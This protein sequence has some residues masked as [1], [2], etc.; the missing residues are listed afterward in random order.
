[1]R[2]IK[3]VVVGAGLALAGC[4]GEQ[5]PC[6]GSA[7]LSV[8]GTYTGTLTQTKAA[9]TCKAIVYSSDGSG[10]LPITVSVGQTG[11]ALTFAL[12]GLNLAG[13]STLFEG[14]TAEFTTSLT[15]LSLNNS[16]PDLKYTITDSESVQFS[17]TGTG[18]HLNS[19]LRDHLVAQGAVGGTQDPDADC[20]LSAIISADFKQP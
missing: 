1:M 18:I 7:C 2:G 20:F 14:N 13:Q 17:K 19:T 9:S 6:T 8:A 5:K 10:S 12:S 11:T 4:G 3:S 15:N 16:R